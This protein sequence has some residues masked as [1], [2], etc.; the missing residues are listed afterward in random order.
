MEMIADAEVRERYLSLALDSRKIID[1]LVVFVEDGRRVP[2]L[3]PSL[4]D[5]VE[6]LRR[7]SG[8]HNIFSPLR[9]E[10]GLEHYEQIRMVDEVSGSVDKQKSIIS[11]LSNVLAA[12]ADPELQKSSAFD[13]ID[14]FYV[15][16]RRAL[17]HYSQPLGPEGI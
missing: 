9:T 1:A 10:L 15:L 2:D 11:K 5:A 3:E 17:H 12:N 6:S 16:E 14:F 4:Q 13:A 8:E 7:A